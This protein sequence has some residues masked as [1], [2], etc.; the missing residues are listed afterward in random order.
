MYGHYRYSLLSDDSKQLLKECIEK[1]IIMLRLK[2][3]KISTPVEYNGQKSQVISRTPAMD[4]Q[5]KV[6][7]AKVGSWVHVSKLKIIKG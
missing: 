6:L 7:I 1:M 3:C 5:G 2:E 4:A